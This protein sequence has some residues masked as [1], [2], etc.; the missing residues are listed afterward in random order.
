MRLSV[1]ADLMDARFPPGVLLPLLDE[2]LRGS[3]GPCELIATRSSGD[4]RVV[5]KLPAR[6]AGG[7]VTRVRTLLTDLY[8]TSAELVVDDVNGAVSATVRVPYERA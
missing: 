2:A 4:C 8:G 3:S 1:S 5:L 6:P 7:A